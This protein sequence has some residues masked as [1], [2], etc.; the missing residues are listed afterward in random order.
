M[1]RVFHFVVLCGLFCAAPALGEGQEAPGEGLSLEAAIQL[2]LTSNPTLKQAFAQIEGAT[3]RAEQ[4]RVWTNPELELRNEDWLLREGSFADSKQLIGLSQTVPLP[5][6]KKLDRQIG[7]AGIAVTDGEWRLRR[8]EIIRDVTRHFYTVLVSER[9][10]GIA[11]EL[12]SLAESLASMA[13]KRVEAGD[14]PYQEQ[15]RAEVQLERARTDRVERERELAVARGILATAIGRPGMQSTNV[16]G[17]LKDTGDP[18]LL[19]MAPQQW[20][21]AHPLTRTAKA[22]V[23]RARLE[24]RRSRLEPYPDVT[25]SAAAGRE[26]VSEAAIAEF[27]VSLPLPLWDRAKGRQKEAKANVAAA[28]AEAAAIEQRLVRE[29]SEARQ[30]VVSAQEQVGAYRDKILPKAQEALRLVGTG[31]DEGKFGLID[32]LDI[33]RTTAEARLAYQQKLLE[34]NIAQAELEALVGQSPRNTP[35]TAQ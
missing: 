7:T 20:L 17:H 2:A 12:V 24:Q 31:F 34:L 33:Q 27:G 22:L 8:A 14:I 25:L 28:E 3:G 15:L 26:G 11:R 29:W 18:A 9:V 5:G 13:R 10:A 1:N 35:P 16:S 19:A 23:E 32:L 21:P 6:K 4:A 30:K